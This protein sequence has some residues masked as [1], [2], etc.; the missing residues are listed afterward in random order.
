MTMN[1]RDIFGSKQVRKD[2][3]VQSRFNVLIVLIVL[4][5]ASLLAWLNA[6]MSE[7]PNLLF[8]ALLLVVGFCFLF[9][10]QELFGLIL[11]H[12]I[13]TKPVFFL[14]GG[15]VLIYAAYSGYST[16]VGE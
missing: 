14:L 16:L 5:L 1:W 12:T 9:L 8:G 15:V 11:T 2:E 10:M 6:R 13:G 4:A 7:E 3:R